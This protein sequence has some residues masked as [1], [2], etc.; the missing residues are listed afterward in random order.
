MSGGWLGGIAILS[1]LALVTVMPAG[2]DSPGSEL[3]RLPDAD[4]TFTSPH[5]QVRVE[6]YSKEKGRIRSRVPILDDRDSGWRCV[7]DTKTGQFSVPF[8][9]ADH[10]A[11]ALKL[12]DR[13]RQ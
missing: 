4:D 1:L 12:P 7:F 3:E 8:D 9:F 5:G 10:N 2:A 6:Q 11:K 13:S